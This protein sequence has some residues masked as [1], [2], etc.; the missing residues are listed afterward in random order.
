MIRSRLETGNF[1]KERSPHAPCR[2]GKEVKLNIKLRFE[3][4]GGLGSVMRAERDWWSPG[5]RER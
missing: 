3:T 1:Q 2:P 5:R 4:G